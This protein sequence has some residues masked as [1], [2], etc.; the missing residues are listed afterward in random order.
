TGY[1]FSGWNTATNGAG[2]AYVA[3]GTYTT[4]VAATLYAQWTPA[5]YSITYDDNGSTGGAPPADQTKTHDV[6]L[7]LA[8]AA[9]LVRTGY[10]FSGWNTATNGAGTTYVAAGTYAT[11]VAA[12][13][14]AQWTPATYTVSYDGN[15]STGGAPPADQ[16]KTHEL[17]LT[18]A[19]TGTLVRTGH[20][21][22][23][24]N[25]ITN[26]SGTAYATGGTYVTNVAATLFAQWTPDTYTVSYD[27]NGSTG[28]APPADQTKTYDVDLILAGAGTLVRTGYSFSGWNTA[29]NGAGTAYVAAG[30]YATN[31]A[32]TLY[33]Q[34]TPATYTVSY[35]GNGSTGG[36]PPADQTKTHELDLTLAGTGTLVRTGHTFGGWNTMTNGSGT[37]YATGGTYVTNVAATL[38][39]QWTPDTYTV[40]YDDNGST[41]GAPPADQTK[42]Y[43]VDLVLAGVG[44]LVKVGH[45]FT[46]W[47]TATN[48]SGASYAAGGTYSADVDATL[49]SRWLSTNNVPLPRATLFTFD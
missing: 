23:G 15:G 41:G 39:A 17:D 25:T 34:W 14:Y 16:T 13:L 29:T 46:G 12:T 42:T 6:D 38:F 31:V 33:A 11:N 27:D 20:T 24:W 47:N 45:T 22:G 3:A 49:Y 40:S 21:F 48:G 44:D 9:T 8:G 35:D 10:S 36:A 7:T 32:A 26:G 37:A 30:T 4:N 28:G 2:T 19:G 5:T 1:S 18:L 43:D